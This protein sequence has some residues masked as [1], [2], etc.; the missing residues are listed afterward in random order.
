MLEIRVDIF[1]PFDLLPSSYNSISLTP[2]AAAIATVGAQFRSQR[3]ELLSARRRRS[4]CPPCFSRAACPLNCPAASTALL[5]SSHGTVS[6]CLGC[7]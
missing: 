2:V 1:S 6:C 7:A 5:P 4:S 3:L